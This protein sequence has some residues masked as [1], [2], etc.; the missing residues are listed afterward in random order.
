MKTK[1]G[2]LTTVDATELARRK[3][4]CENTLRDVCSHID[5]LPGSDGLARR[6]TPDLFFTEG[7]GGFYRWKSNRVEIG[8]KSLA[9][10]STTDEEIKALI[11]HE[12]GHWA[13]PDL[14]RSCALGGAALALTGPLGVALLLAIT[15]SA[16]TVALVMF[17]LLI[18][19]FY[20]LA[21]LGSWRSEFYADRFAARIVGTEAVVQLLGSMNSQRIPQPTHPSPAR[22]I[23]HLR[24]TGLHE[25]SG[26]VS[27]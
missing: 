1:I 12:L 27:L 18:V 23:A 4:L 14:V 15:L 11:G 2:A 5:T 25:G 24:S 16:G 22:R 8:E 20:V 13:D 19:A 9:K 6:P 7:K 21:P 26:V 17:A 10:S 3:V